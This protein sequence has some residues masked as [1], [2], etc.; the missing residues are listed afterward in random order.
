M[1]GEDSQTQTTTQNS[2]TNPWENAQPLLDKLI[3]SYKGQDTGVTSAQTSA[4]DKLVNATTGIPNFGEQGS[5]AIDRLFSSSTDPQSG[6]LTSA[7]ESLKRNVGGTASGA[8]LDPYSTPGFG[9]ALQT[10]IDDITKNTK[11][12]YNASGR[13]PSGAGS[14]AGSLGKGLTEGLAPE[15][16]KQ[17]NINKTN[18]LGAAKTLY[19]AEGGTASQLTAQDQVEFDNLLKAITGGTALPGLYTAPGTAQVGAANAQYQ[20]PWQNLAQLLQPSV[21]MAGLGGQSMGSSTSTATQPQSTLGNIIGGAST[22]IGMLSA[23]GG[24]GGAS[25]GLAALLAA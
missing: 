11:N 24:S 25:A 13:D 16:A 23:I 18:Q 12:V 8:E 2:K 1:P 14:F 21:S 3:A 5:A 6:M 15:I 9:G 22:G 10:M 19:D 7:L 4:L 17:F 20:Q